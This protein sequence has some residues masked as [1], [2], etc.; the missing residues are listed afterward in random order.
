MGQS[1]TTQ[2]VLFEDPNTA[3]Q[4]ELELGQGSSM[5]VPGMKTAIAVIAPN[6]A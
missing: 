3:Y 1:M 5:A 6:P 2:T 4:G